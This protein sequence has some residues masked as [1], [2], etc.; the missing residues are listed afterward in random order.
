MV[1]HE[2]TLKTLCHLKEARHKRPHGVLFHWHEMSRLGKSIETEN[3]FWGC[4]GWSRVWARVILNTYGVCLKEGLKYLEYFILNSIVVMVTLLCEYT[5]N[6]RI[7]HFKIMNFM[8]YKLYFNPSVI[9][10]KKYITCCLRT[11]TMTEQL[12]HFT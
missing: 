9:Q 12:P 2:W 3:R 11:Q 6:H 10:K 5:T 7:V 4:Q 1:K 8:V